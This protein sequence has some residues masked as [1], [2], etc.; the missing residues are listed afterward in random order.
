MSLAAG[1]GAHSPTWLGGSGLFSLYSADTLKAGEFGFSFY[2]N[3]FDRELADI[4]GEKGMDLDISYLSLP[5]AYGIMDQL[6]VFVAPT[7]VMYE[8]QEDGYVGI[9]YDHIFTDSISESGFGD[10]YAGVKYQFLVED[11]APGLAVM[12]FA[13]IPT[14]D[15]EKALGSGEMDYGLKL[16]GTKHLG[17][18][19]LNFNL[20][21]TIIGEPDY[22]EWDNV[23]SYGL[24]LM[25]PKDKNFQFIAELT[26]ETDYDP[27]RDHNPLDLTLGGRFHLANGLLLG[28]GLR[29]G[30]AM[31]FDD[32]PLGG[33][34]QIGYHTAPTPV[35][36]PTPTPAPN[37][38]PFVTCE[39]DSVEV[40]QGNYTRIVARATDADGDPLTYSWTSTGCRIEAN[41]NEARL[42]TDECEPGTY[43][44]TCV[45]TDG[46][47]GEATCSVDITVLVM[48]PKRLD[49][50]DI[51]F[52]AGSRLDNVAKALLDDIALKLKQYPNEKI[53]LIGH[54]DSQGSE[55]SNLKMGETRAKAVRD[56]L[57]KR[58][59]IDAERFVIE[60]AGESKPIA[61]N[62]TEAGRRQNRRV[63]VVMMVKPE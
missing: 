9:L 10:I 61:D 37:A 27:D 32:C 41:G 4:Y 33:V 20:G 26:G 16:I 25:L 13:K 29:Y 24:G 28:A 44:V 22:A 19:G 3:N 30:L 57:V 40:T 7:Y 35:V 58:H 51:P 15:E 55:K 17:S 47:G 14:A 1:A 62:S 21:Y 60:S 6:E 38:A 42:Y 2:F 31:D 49:L 39:A 63:E 54:T 12:A 43:T 48:E 56:Y 8:T 45:V 36:L 52:K 50:P 18:A 59:G 11:G 23:V 46:R 5:I 34:V 53:T